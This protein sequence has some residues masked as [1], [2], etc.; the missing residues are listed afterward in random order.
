MSES[1]GHRSLSSRRREF[2]SFA[3]LLLLTV[4]LLSWLGFQTYQLVGERQQ[5][6]QMR[7]AQEAQVEAAGKVR[8]S[9][10]TVATATA[11]LAD[12][13]NVNARILVAELR[14]RGITINPA[15]PAAAAPK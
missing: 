3:P 9:L 13:G 12:S 6:A 8:A 14:K 1:T 2:N 15:A 10:D 4:T 5:L 7:F 11:K